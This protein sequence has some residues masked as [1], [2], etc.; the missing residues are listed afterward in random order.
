M[1]KDELLG[2]FVTVHNDYALVLAATVLFCEDNAAD[3][4]HYA[5][6]GR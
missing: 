2:C 1:T 3:I 4:E 6:S 5:S